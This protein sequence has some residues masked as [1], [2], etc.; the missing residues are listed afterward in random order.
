MFYACKFSQC[1]QCMPKWFAHLS[2]R[3]KFI[4]THA[5]V[6]VCVHTHIRVCVYTSLTTYMKYPHI[7]NMHTYEIF[8]IY[9][10][11]TKYPCILNIY[12]INVRY[13]YIWNIYEI[14]IYMNMWNIYI[15]FTL[16]HSIKYQWKFKTCCKENWKPSAPIS[17][18]LHDTHHACL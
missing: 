7:W 18:N 6:Y 2:E 8:T 10:I 14:F 16:F 3:W 15:S 4:I 11:Y 12:E 1:F 13:P 9:E 5:C 17:Y